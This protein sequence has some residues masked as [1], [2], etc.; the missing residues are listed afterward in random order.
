VGQDFS[1][2]R[3]QDS[4]IRLLTLGLIALVA[5]LA[6]RPLATNM[7]AA[8]ATATP[9]FTMPAGTGKETF[10]S[11]CSLCH[12]PVAVVGKQ[13]TKREWEAKVTEMLQEEPDVTG[14]E[15][16]AIVEYLTA[17][18]KPGGKIYVNIIAAKDLATLLDLTID[19]ATALVQRREQRGSFKTLEEVKAV[20]GI[21][22]ARGDAARE[23]LA[24]Q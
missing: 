19:Q 8:Q 14:E 13:F 21:D 7:L 20:T 24:F 23:R 4:G 22:T 17:S 10:E 2:G 11:V 12:N 6:A 16:A 18:F 9:A 5:A 15:R 3:D 1:P